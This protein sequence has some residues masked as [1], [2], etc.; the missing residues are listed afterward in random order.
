VR[1]HQEKNQMANKKV[2]VNA[3]YHYVP[4]M[5]DRCNPPIAVEMGRLTVGDRVKVVNL[6]G[7]PKAN[8]MG[9]AHFAAID[10]KFG[11]LCRTNSLLSQ[12]E[13]IEYLRLRIAQIEAVR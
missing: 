3:T 1:I 7:C 12:S 8:T 9:H 6:P 2:R 4:V 10:G 13:Y 5:I 11:G